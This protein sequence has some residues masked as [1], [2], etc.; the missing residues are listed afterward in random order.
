VDEASN[1]LRV[2]LIISA[3]VF[4]EFFHRVG[5][6]RS[7]YLASYDSDWICYYSRLL[8]KEGIHLVWYLFSRDIKGPEVEVHRPTGSE[9]RFLPGP[10]L[11]NWWT[12]RLPFVHHFALHLATCSLTLFRDLREQ[13]PDLLYVQDYESGRFDVMSLMG[14][15]LGIPV[16]GQYQGGH[17][18]AQWPLR[19]LRRWA[20]RRAA[21]LLSPNTEEHA[22]LKSAHGLPDER[23]RCFPNPVPLFPNPEGSRAVRE[24]LGIPQTHRYVLFLGRLVNHHKGVDVLV[25]AFRGLAARFPDVHLV[26]AGTGQDEKVLHEQA[27]NVPR[28]HFLGW[29]SSRQ[30]VQELLG[31]SEVV[32]CPSH[33]DAFPYAVA[34]AMTA[35]RPLV[36]S[37]VGGIRDLV[38]DGRTGYLVPPGDPD[39]LERALEKILQDPGRAAAMGRSGRAR[40]EQEFA[41]TVLV[42]RLAGMLRAAVGRSP[43]GRA[44]AVAG[45]QT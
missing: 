13:R 4:E 16:V 34:E 36:A 22:R 27:R 45:A 1:I 6:T 23:A 3:P 8:R 42:P 35:G 17:S 31:A 10:R 37:A 40:I 2:A 32:A 20:L 15:A 33:E 11:Y 43:K 38:A 9:V 24:S 12:V 28:V 5:V 44:G 14:A 39:A 25:S 26:V 7:T 30:R 18:P 21:Y 41:E 19:W 29:V